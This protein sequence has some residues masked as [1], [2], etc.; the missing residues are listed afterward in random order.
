MSTTM[1]IVKAINAHLRV[2]AHLGYLR[3]PECDVQIDRV[4]T[5]VGARLLQCHAAGRE[6]WFTID[7]SQRLEIL[8][9]GEVIAKYPGSWFLEDAALPPVAAKQN[10]VIGTVNSESPDSIKG[11]GGAS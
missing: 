1:G 8:R 4:R 9:N 11:K 10:E 5:F 3:G 7:S 6:R 2:Q